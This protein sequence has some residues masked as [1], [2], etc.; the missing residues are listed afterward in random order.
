M[1]LG[2]NQSIYLIVLSLTP[3]GNRL[4]ITII[5]GELFSMREKAFR[6]F[7]KE[8]ECDY[9]AMIISILF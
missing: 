9:T 5:I 4:W 7:Q 3:E 6:H 8:A 2:L 1:C